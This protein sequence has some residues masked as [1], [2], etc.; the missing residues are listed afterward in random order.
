[1]NYA[2]LRARRARECEFQTTFRTSWTDFY[3]I[4]SV[5]RMTNL[6]NYLWGQNAA[7]RPSNPAAAAVAVLRRTSSDDDP[8]PAAHP[9]ADLYG[10]VG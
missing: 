5:P 1:V 7:Q 9:V 10:V 2:Q 4:G 6:L 8:G 3:E